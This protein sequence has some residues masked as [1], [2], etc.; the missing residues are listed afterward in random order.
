MQKHASFS[1]VQPGGLGPAD[2]GYHV[3]KSLS[4]VYRCTCQDAAA[5]TETG[6]GMGAENACRGRVKI[7]VETTN[8]KSELGVYGM[9]VV[10]E[11]SHP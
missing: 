9:N 11:T 1:S 7:L 6:A 5:G 10:V 3:L 2:G 8:E 4:T